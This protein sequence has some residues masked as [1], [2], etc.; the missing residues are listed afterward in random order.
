MTPQYDHIAPLIEEPNPD[1]EAFYADMVE[2]IPALKGRGKIE[3]PTAGFKRALKA[4][5]LAGSDRE[6]VHYGLTYN[7]RCPP[8][9][10]ERLATLRRPYLDE[11]IMRSPCCPP[12]LR[13]R[14]EGDEAARAFRDQH[15]FPPP[16][17]D[18][19]LRGR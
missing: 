18:D 15:R 11:A 17:R 14:L 7:P 6:Q 2:D 16:I 10:L 13:A 8:E 9:L 12:E 19:H 3:I 4:A 5:W 1:F